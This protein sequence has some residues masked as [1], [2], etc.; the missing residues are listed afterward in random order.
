MNL[1]M[2]QFSLLLKSIITYLELKIKLKPNRHD[3]RRLDFSLF[4]RTKKI[5]I[6]KEDKD[7]FDIIFTR[8]EYF[9]NSDP[10]KF[11]YQY[12]QNLVRKNVKKYPFR[13]MIF[14]S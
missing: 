4:C 1:V 5:K 9:V 13:Q 10:K 12:F 6:I 7:E 3:I 8:N 11:K 2:I 14:E